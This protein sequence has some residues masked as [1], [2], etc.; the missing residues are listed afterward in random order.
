VYI[1]HATGLHNARKVSRISGQDAP[2]NSLWR[3]LLRTGVHEDVG[4][5]TFA[6]WA[7]GVQCSC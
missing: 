2:L 1:V 5:Y 7:V 3:I 6:V 4:D